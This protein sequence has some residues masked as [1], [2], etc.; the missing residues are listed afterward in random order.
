MILSQPINSSMFGHPAACRGLIGGL[1]PQVRGLRC[2]VICLGRSPGT[3]VITADHQ[4]HQESLQITRNTSSNCKSPRTPAVTAD[5]QI[6]R[7]TNSYCRSPGTPAVTAD[8]QEHQQSLQITRNT[9]QQSLQTTRNTSSHCRSPGTPAVTRNTS[10]HCRPP[11][12]PAVTA[13][14]S[15]H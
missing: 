4:E 1:D 12:T 2:L 14:T 3:P 6:T 11:G 5:H 15:S 7:N 8:H 13:D 10:S 9:M